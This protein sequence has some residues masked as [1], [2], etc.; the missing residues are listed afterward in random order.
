MA[1]QTI[2]YGDKSYLNQNA[3]IPATNKVQDTDMNEIKSVVNNNANETSNNTTNIDNI[4]N[5]LNGTVL[6]ENSIGSSSTFTIN[7]NI[8]NYSKILITYSRTDGAQKVSTFLDIEEIGNASIPLSL[9][10]AGGSNFIIYGCRIS[11]SNTTV[12][13]S[14]NGAREVLSSTASINNSG[15]EISINKIIGYK[16]INIEGE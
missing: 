1:V 15:Y 2:T 4:V 3:D 12:T 7:D 11:F 9:V 16:K 14:N 6:Y 8:S 5:S 13:I 10:D